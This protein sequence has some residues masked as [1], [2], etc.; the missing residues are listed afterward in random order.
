[1][2]ALKNTL[3]KPLRFANK[4]SAKSIFMWQQRLII[5]AC[6]ILQMPGMMMQ[7]LC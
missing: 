1:M 3:K 7:Y 2:I 5:S 4:Y 6:Y